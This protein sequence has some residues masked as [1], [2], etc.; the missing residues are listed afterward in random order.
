MPRRFYLLLTLAILVGA[1]LRL[2]RLTL[3]PPGLH[4]DL[5]ATALLGNA[6]AFNGY[7]PIFIA[8]Y[9]GH[10]V[11]F[12]YWLALWFRLVGSSVFTL[13]LAAATLGL[14][15]LPAAYFAIRQVVRF[16]ENSRLLAVFAAAFLAFAFFHVAFSR[17]GFRVITEP[18]IQSL[19]LGFLFRGLHRS[20][21]AQWDASRWQVKSDSRQAKIPPSP[22]DAFALRRQG[23]QTGASRW[24]V[25]GDSRWAKIPPSPDDAFALRRQER[26][27]GGEVWD[28]ALAGFFT[29][30]AAYTYLAARLFPFPLAIFWLALLLGAIRN[31]LHAPRFTLHASRSTP[32]AIWSLGFLVFF[33]SAFL[34]FLP[35]GLYFLLHPADFLNRAGQVAPRPGEAALLLQEEDRKSTRLNSSHS[36]A[37][38]MPSSA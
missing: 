5:A 12:Y 33:F 14:L 9:T 16:E 22:D 2:W 31:T 34:T 30:L 10:E 8:A 1:F 25:A 15:T 27:P 20:V 11:L 3:V 36:R 26:G 23:P 35:L 28:F 18:L 19:A 13:R 7:R 29:G 32:F 37:S 17:F 4:Y 21:E 24:R 38:R 6:V